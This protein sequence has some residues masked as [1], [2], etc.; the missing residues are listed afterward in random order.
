M[1]RT[2]WT[3]PFRRARSLAVHLEMR[4]VYAVA[5]E[6]RRFAEFQRTGTVDADADALA[7]RQA[8]LELV[9]ELT[10]RGVAVRRAR[11]VSEPV[12][13]YIRWEHAITPA[14]LA[15]GEQVRW[16]P[17]HRA[18][19]LMLPGADFWLF[20]DDLVRF[21]HFTGDGE[22]RGHEQR[23]DPGLLRLCR[24]AFEHVWARA[25]PHQEYEIV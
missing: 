17:R 4:D 13:D 16:L 7:H 24:D 25:I 15:A 23:T 12:T 8:W 2:D 3:D 11:I 21:G 20:D 5:S 14:N 1:P 18:A 10:D 6:A 19:D 22:L 9:R